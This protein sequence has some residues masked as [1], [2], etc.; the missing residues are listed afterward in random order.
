MEFKALGYAK[1]VWTQE[2]V[3]VVADGDGKTRM[4]SYDDIGAII[5]KHRE[6]TSEDE[7][8]RA[9][10]I[11]KGNE[12]ALRNVLETLYEYD[13]DPSKKQTLEPLMHSYFFEPPQTKSALQP[14]P[15]P[16]FTLPSPN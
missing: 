12:A 1:N 16:P 9:S 13:S 7:K 15:P 8:D 6:S 2:A 5:E 14:L 4:L 3:I 10:Y 11:S